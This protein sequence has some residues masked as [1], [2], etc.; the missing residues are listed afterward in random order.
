LKSGEAV[1]STSIELIPS[2][3]A[4]ENYLNVLKDNDWVFLK[5][6]WNSMIVALGTTVV[7]ILLAS[8]AAY[9]FSRFKFPGRKTGLMVFLIT[10][11]FPGI[12]LVIPLYEVMKSMRLLNSY[13]GLII[14]Y[15]TTALPFCVF[16]LKSYFDAI[17]K[18]LE[19]AARIDGLNQ[20]SIFYKI[21]VPLALPGIAVTGFFSMITAWNEFMLALTFM[22]KEEMYMLPVGLKKYVFDYKTEWHMVSAAAILITVPVLVVWL[23]IQTA[24]LSGK[25]SGAVKG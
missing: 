10:Q 12:I 8:T 25:L 19:D 1:F 14:A 20:W 15:S 23:R 13:T 17:P 24:L 16:M 6:I 9:A 18:S 22:S 4:F 5:W 3:F 21:M 11:M 7:G 2:K